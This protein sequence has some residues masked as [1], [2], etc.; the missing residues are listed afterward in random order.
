[1]IAFQLRQK[2]N[3]T[4][5]KRSTLF[6]TDPW[7]YTNESKKSRQTGIFNWTISPFAERCELL[8]AEGP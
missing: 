1:M 4:L 6:A 8:Y 2:P 5:L 3:R 7:Y